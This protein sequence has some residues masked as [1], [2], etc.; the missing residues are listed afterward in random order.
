MLEI[1]VIIC[2]YNRASELHATLHSWLMVLGTGPA[3]ELIIVDNNSTDDTQSVGEAFGRSYPYPV[4]YVRE[5]KIGLSNARNRGI[6]EARGGV[7]A[8]VD[9]DVNFDANWLNEI[10]AAFKNRPN[11]SRVGGKS[12]PSFEKEKPAWITDDVYKLY[13]ATG[14]GDHDREMVF[15]EH[16]FGLNMVFKNDVFKVVGNFNNSL[17]R[18][19]NSLLSNEETDLFYRVAQAGLKVFYA[20]KAILYH[21]IPAERMDKRWIL[22]RMYWQGISNVAYRQIIRPGTNLELV[23]N[24]L[25]N[26][27]NIFRF[28]GRKVASHLAPFVGAPTF[29]RQLSVYRSMGIARQNMLEIFSIFKGK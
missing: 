1:S 7:V 23:L 4:R 16:P 5:P 15:P 8:F 20:S 22:K 3:V 25:E 26:C 19:K 11:A 10:L 13:G 17:G 21:R 12:I 24:T 18:I 14:S 9:D 2:T 6:E 28:Y 29:R 27:K